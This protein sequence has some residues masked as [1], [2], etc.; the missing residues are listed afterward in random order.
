MPNLN[1]V[2]YLGW[3]R[4]FVSGKGE[5]FG[6]GKE[7]TTGEPRPGRS[8]CDFLKSLCPASYWYISSVRAAQLLT[9]ALRN[10]RY[11]DHLPPSVGGIF[12]MKYNQ[13]CVGM[14][15]VIRFSRI[16]RSHGFEFSTHPHVGG[17][18]RYNVAPRLQKERG[19]RG[20]G[21]I[22]GFR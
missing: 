18:H 16:Q 1:K 21:V 20:T 6:S 4:R 13:C 11:I 22:E 17:S 7:M 15:A 14:T 19:P 8:K 10:H 12:D 2:V 5:R 3:H 9:R